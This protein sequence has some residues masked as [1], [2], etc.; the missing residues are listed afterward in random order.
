MTLLTYPD[1]LLPFPATFEADA[2]IIRYALDQIK[3]VLNGNV[4]DANLAAGAVT[5]AKLAPN[6]ISEDKI[7]ANVVNDDKVCDEAVTGPKLAKY[8]ETKSVGAG[9]T[10]DFTHNKGTL[11]TICCLLYTTEMSIP[12]PCWMER[13]NVNTIR[14]H[15]SHP[16]QAFTVMVVAI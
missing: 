3:A 5:A 16:T 10:A 13:L 7:A 9:S 12:G 6:S 11:L 15:N 8:S 14:V 1:P 4:D 2:L